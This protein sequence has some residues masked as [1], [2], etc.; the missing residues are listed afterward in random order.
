V[1]LQRR[2]DATRAFVRASFGGYLADW[3]I[4]AAREFSR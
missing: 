1:L 2:D 3:L 4:D